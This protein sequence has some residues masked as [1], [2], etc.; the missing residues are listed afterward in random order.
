[1]SFFIGCGI[2]L[3]QAGKY[4]L[5][6]EVRHEKAGF[7]NLPA[8]TLHVTEDL[9]Q[10]VTREAR[11]ETGAEVAVEHLVGIYQTV[12]AT[13]DNVVFTVFAGS[14]AP[15]THFHS[16]EHKVIQ[17]FSYEEIEQLDRAGKLRSPIVLQAITDHRGGQQLPLSAVQSWHVETLASITVDK[18]H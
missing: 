17:T 18:D 1:M 16:E 5:V 7:L 8:G 13:G 9:L 3:E 15:D 11:E 12:T 10:C 6:E 14:C 4:V 2:V